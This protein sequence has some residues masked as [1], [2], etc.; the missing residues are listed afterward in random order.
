MLLL[1]VKQL[2]KL[3]LPFISLVQLIF[4]LF[5]K[6][7]PVIYFFFSAWI[8]FL[9]EF[10]FSHPSL[11]NFTMFKGLQTLSERLFFWTMLF[12]VCKLKDGFAWGR[13]G[14]LGQVNYVATGTKYCFIWTCMQSKETRNGEKN[15]PRGCSGWNL[16][17]IVDDNAA[18]CV[19]T[20]KKHTFKS[21]VTKVRK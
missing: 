19:Y 13:G 14:R 8:I 10:M 21:F 17:E 9:W 16:L 6:Y 15:D 3:S 4:S 1:K 18:S 20:I 2:F 7:K 11:T 12:I 5:S